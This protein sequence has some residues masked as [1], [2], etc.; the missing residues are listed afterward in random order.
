ML[1]SWPSVDVAPKILVLPPAAADLGEAEAACEL[2][3]HYSGK[4]LDD[5]QRIAVYVMM[6]LGP[7]GR[8][9][10]STTG[11]EK[12][13]QNGKGDETEVVELWG[14]VQRAEVILH[15]VHDAALLATGFPHDR[16]T[17]PDNNYAAF[18]ALDARSHGVRRCAAAALE[19][20]IVADGGYD[21]FWDR[22]LSSWDVAAAVCLI[23]ESGGRVTHLSGAPFALAAKVDILASNRRLHDPL[24]DALSHVRALP[25][26]D[27][28]Q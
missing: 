1:T 18:V 5:D 16:A 26:H 4:T 23:E 25:P 15:T 11:R 7:D 27:G 10:A 9:A 24:K 6:A 28:V 14:L 21:G 12:A 8:W 3:E 2:W 19:L 22:G 20:A 13:R 17:N